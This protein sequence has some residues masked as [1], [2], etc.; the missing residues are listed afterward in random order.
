MG[1]EVLG[2]LSPASG[3][4]APLVILLGCGNGSSLLSFIGSWDEF[5]NGPS[6][7]PLSF[8]CLDKEK[9]ETFRGVVY[10]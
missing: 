5:D 3:L 7:L 6:G 8:L 9:S 1:F 10:F 4:P 2:S